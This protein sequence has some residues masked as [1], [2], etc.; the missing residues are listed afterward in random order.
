VLL[1]ALY[2]GF[3][4][5]ADWAQQAPQHRLISLYTPQTQSGNRALVRALAGHLTRL[6][7]DGKVEDALRTS[8]R[9]VARVKTAHGHLPRAHFAEIL[10]GLPFER[11]PR[12]PMP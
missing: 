11:R 2:G 9:I 8:L 6:S 1:D 3:Q 10:R 4:V 5:F 12:E 7:I